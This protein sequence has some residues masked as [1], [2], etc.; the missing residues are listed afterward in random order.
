MYELCCKVLN[1]K[2]KRSK[3]TREFQ[4]IRALQTIQERN[5]LTLFS[6]YTPLTETDTVQN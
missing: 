3:E 2:E 5:V 6:V 4:A 1:F